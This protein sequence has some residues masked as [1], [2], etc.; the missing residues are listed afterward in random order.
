VPETAALNDCVCD[1]LR[2]TLKGVTATLTV[3]TSEIVA[4]ALFVASAALVAVTV[5]LC[6]VK[7]VAGAIYKPFA[8]ITPTDGFSAHVTPLFDVP[9]TLAAN[10]MLCDALRFAAPGDTETTTG[11]TSDTV[12]TAV[13]VGSAMLVAVMV[14]V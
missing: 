2:L 11:G 4:E 6:A 14:T 12:A 1:A 10:V 7:M 9:E 13:F 3:G 8:V 5:T